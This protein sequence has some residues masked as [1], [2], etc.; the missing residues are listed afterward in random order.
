[1]TPRRKALISSFVVVWT[2]LFHYESLRYNYL[3]RWFQADLPKL[4]LLFPPA[5]WIMFYRVDRS[6]GRAEVW[7]RRGAEAGLIDPHR[8]FATRW[9]GYDNIRRN[10]LITALNQAYAPSFCRYLRRKFPGYDGFVVMEVWTPSVLEPDRQV[11]QL[12]YRCE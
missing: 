6:D 12:A 11:K 9:V 1:M 4:K 8:I 5:G 7:G 10:V 2:A 3:N